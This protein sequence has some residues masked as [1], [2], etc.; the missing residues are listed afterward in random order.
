MQSMPRVGFPVPLTVG[1]TLA[2]V[3]VLSGALI[4]PLFLH[5]PTCSAPQE[6]GKKRGVCFQLISSSRC[7]S[8]ALVWERGT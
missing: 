2:V 4:P 3:W 5:L 6:K 1:A 7:S 8:F